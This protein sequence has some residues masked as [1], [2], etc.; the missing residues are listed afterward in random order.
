MTNVKEEM[1][2]NSVFQKVYTNRSVSDMRHTV[3]INVSKTIQPSKSQDTDNKVNRRP[4]IKQLSIS[5]LP[6]TPILTNNFL[7]VYLKKFSYNLFLSLH[8]SPFQWLSP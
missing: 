7:T 8:N 2:L 4:P 6:S 3:L 5:P 1:T